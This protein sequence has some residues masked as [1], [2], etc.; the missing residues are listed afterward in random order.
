MRSTSFLL[1]GSDVF[2][3]GQDAPFFHPGQVPDG[4]GRSGGQGW[5]QATA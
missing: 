5:P 1:R 3:F 4:A 2:L